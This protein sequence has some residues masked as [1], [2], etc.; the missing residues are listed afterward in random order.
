MDCFCFFRL[1]ACYWLENTFHLTFM[2]KEMNLSAV[3]LLCDANQ[4]TARADDWKLFLKCT[5]DQS[6]DVNVFLISWYNHHN[7]QKSLTFA[8]TFY[9]Q[10]L[11]GSMDKQMKSQK[12]PFKILYYLHEIQIQIPHNKVVSE[13]ALSRILPIMNI[14]LQAPSCLLVHLVVFFQGKRRHLGGICTLAEYICRVLIQSF[15]QLT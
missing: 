1:N 14:F 12:C 4:S 11:I 3:R 6:L 13:P 15:T 10:N 8:D 2:Q 7:T 5:L 9:M